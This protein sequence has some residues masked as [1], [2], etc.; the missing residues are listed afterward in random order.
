[1]NKT[2]FVH[3]SNSFSGSNFVDFLLKKNF[4]V[5]GISRSKEINSVY[6]K[7]KFNNNLSKFQFYKLDINKD[8][9]K[10]IFLIRK[11]KPKI[12]VNYIAQGMVAES[13]INPEDW[14]YTNIFSQT[15]FYKLIKKFKFVKKIIHVTTP[16]VYGSNKKKIN[17]NMKFNPNTPYAISRAAMDIHLKK[18]FQNYNLPIIF[19]RTA[20]V[21]GPCQQLY[22]IVPKTMI[23][24][25]KN[26]KLNLDGGGRSIRSFI[27]IEDASNATFKIM[28]SGKL[29]ET[30]HISTNKFTSIKKLVS[31]IAQHNNKKLKQIIK[32]S[33]DRIGKDHSYKLSSNKIRKELNWKE[34]VS[35]T[36]GIK[37]T[38]E[39]ISNNFNL[40]KN[41]PI[42][43]KHK[44]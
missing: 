31:Q 34:N 3:G 36:K 43:Y 38:N 41:H 4:N 25:K 39:W 14:Y 1:M 2:I 30:Y 22:R 44:T 27:Y 33:K 28:S 37:L 9:K 21:Y 10:I 19:T 26:I 15:K 8:L 7:Y 16:E 24:I 6:L 20:N 29:G 17:E 11:K 5:I 23:S 12:I 32:L 40:L 13:W 35:L 42:K 18:Y